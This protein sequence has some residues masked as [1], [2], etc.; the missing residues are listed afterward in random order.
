[1]RAFRNLI[2]DEK[3][4]NQLRDGLHIQK[5]YSRELVEKLRAVYDEKR[6]K[7]FQ[8]HLNQDFQTPFINEE[9]EDDENKGTS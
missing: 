1:M 3:K 5:N 9:K 6:K 8:S 2:K 4:M 7:E